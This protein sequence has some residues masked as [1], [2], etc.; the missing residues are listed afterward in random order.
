MNGILLL[1]TPVAQHSLLPKPTT[2][3]AAVAE[4]VRRLIAA[5]PFDTLAG[6]LSLSVRCGV[7]E[8]DPACPDFP[9]LLRRAETALAIARLPG[10]DAIQIWHSHM[11]PS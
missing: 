8:N 3:A 6:A 10:Q 2:V 4:W 9:T 1:E 5:P 7:A 11:E